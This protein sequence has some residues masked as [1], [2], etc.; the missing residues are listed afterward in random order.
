VLFAHYRTA[1]DCTAAD[2]AELENVIEPTGY[3]HAKAK[4]LISLGQ[5][6]CDRFGGE[7]PDTLDQLVT[8]PGVGRKTANV[9]LGEAIAPPLTE[10]DTAG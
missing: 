2:Q 6:L 9:V 7:V 10:V 3:Y 1:G 8:L 5:A 4:A